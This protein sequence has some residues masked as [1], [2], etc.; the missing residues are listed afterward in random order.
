MPC[1]LLRRAIEPPVPPPAAYCLA[2]GGA[3]LSK[4]NSESLS[5][6]IRQV[7]PPARKVEIAAVILLLSRCYAR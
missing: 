1:G 5:P 2:P 4:M 6:C 3:A 7:K